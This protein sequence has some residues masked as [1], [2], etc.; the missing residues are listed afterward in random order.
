MTSQSHREIGA[1]SVASTRTGYGVCFSVTGDPPR[2][3]ARTAGR[4]RGPAQPVPR[5]AY[6]PIAERFAARLRGSGVL[7]ACLPLG[8][9]VQP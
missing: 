3:P 5:P 9:D 6:V 4:S 1:S 7:V 8:P 2:S